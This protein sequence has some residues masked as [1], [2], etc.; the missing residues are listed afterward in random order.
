MRVHKT[1]SLQNFC[2]KLYKKK[3]FGREGA[4]FSGSHLRSATDS[5]IFLEKIDLT[6]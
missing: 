5:V 2:Q 1:I 6:S 4:P 3:N